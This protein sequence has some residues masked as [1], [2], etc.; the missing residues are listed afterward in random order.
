MSARPRHSAQM[1]SFRPVATLSTKHK[2]SQRLKVTPI[3]RF[4]RDLLSAPRIEQ[5]CTTYKSQVPD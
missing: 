5:N 1:P 4:P 2:F 3:E